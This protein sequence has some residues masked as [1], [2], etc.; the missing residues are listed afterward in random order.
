MPTSKGQPISRAT[1]TTAQELERQRQDAER[2]LAARKNLKPLTTAHEGGSFSVLNP[3]PTKGGTAVSVSAGTAAVAVS[4]TRTHVQTYLDEIAPASI[5]GRMVKF[6]AK[7]GRFF[8]ADDDEEISADD[9]FVV[10]VDQTLIGR[11]KFNGKG[12]PPDRRMG[13]LYDG[14]VM[15]DRKD[16]GDNDQAKWEIG[17]D[18]KPAD[19]WQHHIYLVVQNVAT[20]ELFTFVTSTDTGRR[21]AGTLLRHYDRLTKTHPDMYPVVRLK[22]GGFN[23]RDERVGWVNTPMFAVVGRMPKDS[24][25]KPDTSLASQMDD[26]LPY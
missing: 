13:L 18:G 16:L 7:S 9:D 4:D 23:H 24:A 6:D 19:P 17:L 26:E 1:R 11:V 5:V 8:T 14:F 22:V 2:D 20:G 3:P 25:A 10:L 21:A 15:P 12:E